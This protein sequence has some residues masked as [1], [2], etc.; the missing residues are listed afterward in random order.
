MIVQCSN[1]YRVDETHERPPQ[2][3]GTTR[4]MTKQQ[5]LTSVAALY[6]VGNLSD[7]DSE[8]REDWTAP[9]MAGAACCAALDSMLRE[10]TQSGVLT[11]YE[12]QSFYDNM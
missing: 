9:A 10:M 2:P 5:F 8:E 4:Q 1:R 11:P 12:C 6:R 3:E 7:S